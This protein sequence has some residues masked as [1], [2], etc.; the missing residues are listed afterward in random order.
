MSGPGL[1]DSRLDA[2]LRRAFARIDTSPGFE[3]RLA[4]RVAALRPEPADLLRERVERGRISAAKRLRREAWMNAA[5]VAGVGAAALAVVWR[6]GPAVAGWMEGVLAAMVDPRMLGGVA[7]AGL[8]AGLWP[9]LRGLLP[10]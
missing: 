9:I 6:Q 5:S 10:R 1:E 3:A 2:R 8:A 7:I 4:A